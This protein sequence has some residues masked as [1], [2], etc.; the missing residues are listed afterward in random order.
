MD[1]SLFCI[2]LAM[3]I[4]LV[5]VSIPRRSHQISFSWPMHRFWENEINSSQWCYYKV[6]LTGYLANSYHLFNEKNAKFQEMATHSS[7]LAWRIP[8]M[9]SHRVGHDWSDLAA[10]T[11]HKKR[12][13]SFLVDVTFEPSKNHKLCHS[14]MF[15]RITWVNKCPLFYLASEKLSKNKTV[16]LLFCYLLSN[17]VD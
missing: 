1:Q 10:A 17:N 7:V 9:G 11:A 15:L 13:K 6:M 3:I 4:S 2:T 8:G 14:S 12:D 5:W 16:F